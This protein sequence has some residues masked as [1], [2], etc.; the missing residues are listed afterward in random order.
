MKT[1]TTNEEIFG[2]PTLDGIKSQLIQ[3]GFDVSDEYQTIGKGLSVFEAR[4]INENRRI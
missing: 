4:K 1:L 3:T 2:F